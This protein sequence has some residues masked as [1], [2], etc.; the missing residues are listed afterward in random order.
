MKCILIILRQSAKI[1]RRR[2]ERI[3]TYNKC[4][5]CSQ[6]T[7]SLTIKNTR[8]VIA[9]N[10]RYSGTIMMKFKISKILHTTTYAHNN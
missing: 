5:E 7:V 8:N 2:R 10:W 6:M 9:S 1:S 4:T 3:K